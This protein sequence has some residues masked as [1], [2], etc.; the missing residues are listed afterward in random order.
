[1]A[2]L[3]P[4]NSPNLVLA[5]PTKEE[6]RQTWTLTAKNW[7]NALSL[8]DYLEREEFLENIP[9]TQDGGVTHWILTDSTLPPNSR[10][11]LS[12]C[13]SLRRPTILALPDGTIKSGVTH[14]IGSVFC[15]PEYRKMGY[16]TRM[17]KL[18]G[19]AL[20]THQK[21][22]AE[23]PFSVLYSDIGKKYYANLGW[24]V[25][26]SSHLSL[27]AI[28]PTTTNGH[29]EIN[30]TSSSNSTATP[31]TQE[32]FPDLLK[33]DLDLLTKQVKTTAIATKKPS[34]AIIPDSETIQWHH[35]RQTFMLSKLFPTRAAPTINGAIS[36]GAPGSRIWI[37][38]SR[39]FYG[40]LTDAAAGN[41]FYVL[42]LVVEDERVSDENAEKLAAVLRVAQREAGEWELKSVAVWNVSG[43][44]KELLGKTGMQWEEV[45]REE[46]SIASLMWYGEGE[47][48]PAEVENI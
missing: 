42:R 47:G 34:F 18:L 48:G 15:P 16:A 20:A 45:E 40:P 11:L 41:K 1:M 29:N 3:P 8:D 2:N 21:E 19:P 35:L 7:G 26:P 14:G 46:D 10:P 28:P 30:G 17:L 24:K 27:P 33:Q 44:V 36:T 38:F 6:K 4:A 43:V 37:I 32:D 12:S 22:I 23:C 25:F 39:V 31:L 9:Q 5:H 13:E